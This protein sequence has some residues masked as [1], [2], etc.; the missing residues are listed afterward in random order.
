MFYAV[1]ITIF[2]QI[3]QKA[4][5]PNEIMRISM[6]YYPLYQDIHNCM[7]MPAKQN[8]LLK[9]KIFDIQNILNIYSSVEYAKYYFN[10]D[11]PREK[12]ATRLWTDKSKNWNQLTEDGKNEAGKERAL[13]HNKQIKRKTSFNENIKL[14]NKLA[15]FCEEREINL[16]V[17]VTPASKYYRDNLC[18]EYKEIFYNVLESTDGVIH[19]LDLFDEESYLDEDF[20]DMDHLGDKGAYKMTNTVLDILHEL[21]YMHILLR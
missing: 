6:V 3:Y 17:V 15:I 2:S 9:S 16:V 12:F 13:R 20:N 10:Q 18:L 5:D 21:D 11:R 4:K 1:V 19:L 7:L 8:I 14:F